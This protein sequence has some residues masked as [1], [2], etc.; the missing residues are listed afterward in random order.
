MNLSRYSQEN[1]NHSM[2]VTTAMHVKALRGGSLQDFGRAR[3]MNVMEGASK[4]QYLILKISA[5]IVTVNDS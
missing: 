5:G 1:R 4:S 3:D 2:F